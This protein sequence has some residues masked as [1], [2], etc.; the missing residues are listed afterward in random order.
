MLRRCDGPATERLA[1]LKEVVHFVTWNTWKVRTASHLFRTENGAICEAA[2]TW[3]LRARCFGQLKGPTSFL[4]Q[5]L[6]SRRSG[7]TLS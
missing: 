2:V 4:R 7:L 3:I 1:D 5:E 6:S